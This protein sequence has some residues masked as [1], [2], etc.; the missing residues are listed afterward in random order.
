MEREIYIEGY[1]HT[2]RLVNRTVRSVTHADMYIDGLITYPELPSNYWDIDD[3]YER[4]DLWNISVTKA[5]DHN[6]ELLTVYLSKIFLP[7]IHERTTMAFSRMQ[8]QPEIVVNFLRLK[9]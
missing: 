7:R 6:R 3:R 2:A 9:T 8:L 4:M 5:I 1:Y